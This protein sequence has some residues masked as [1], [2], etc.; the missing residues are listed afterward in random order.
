MFFTIISIGTLFAS[1]TQ[2]DGIWYNFNDN[3]LTAEVTYKGASYDS[4][5]STKYSGTITI[6]TSVTYSGKSYSVTSIGYGAFYRCTGLTSVTIPN[7]VTSIGER[8]FYQ[9]TGLTSVTIGNSVTSIGESAFELCTSLT[10]VTIPDSVI[11]I[12]RCAFDGCRGLTSVTI[13]NS[14]TNIGN[15]VFSGCTSLTSP[16]YNAHVFAYMPTTYSGAYTIPNGIESIAE[17]AFFECAGLTSVIIPNSVTSIGGNAF[18]RCTGLTSVIMGNGITSIGAGAFYSCIS[19]TSVTIPNSV[20]SIGNYAFL[21]CTGLTDIYVSCGDLRRVAQMLNSDDRVKVKYKPLPYS[22]TINTTNG[23]VSAP[24]NICDALELTATPDYGYHFTQW[25][26]G[27]TDNPRAF[28]L[29]Q[30]TTFSAEFA[31]NPTITYVYDKSSGSVNG[32]IVLAYDTVGEITFEATPNYGY[33]FVQWSDGVT[34][35][36]RTAIIFQDTTFAAEFAKNTYSIITESSN[37]EWGTT[38]GNTS[39]LY[40]EQVEIS[41]TANYGYHFLRWSD[42]ESDNPRTIM[43]TNDSVLTAIF[44]PNLYTIIG[45]SDSEKGHIDGIG[46]YDYLTRVT[47]IAIP[48]YGYH[49]DHWSDGTTGN[50]RTIILTQD[51]TFTA[52]FAIDKNGVCG[53]DSALK[54]TYEDKSQ[55]LTITGEGDLTENYTYGVEAPTQMKILIISNDVTSI[56]DSAFYGMTTINHLTIGGNV[57]SIGNYAFAECKNFD[58]ITC[59]ATTVPTIDYTT[60]YNVGNKQY[61]YLYVPADRERA[62]KRDTWWGQF[63]IQIMGATSTETT[64]VNV[65]PSDNSATIVWPAVSGAATYELV[66]K[67]KDGNIICTLIFN[68][69]GQLTSIA[70]NAPGRNAPQQTQSAGFSFTVTGLDS[71][72]GY[73]MTMTSKDSNGAIL[74]TETISFVTNSPQALDPVTGNPSSITHKVIKDGQLFILR[75]DKTYTLTGQEVK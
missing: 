33:H 23:N 44:A 55:T 62:Y 47:L 43:I 11:S 72:T 41:A 38:A 8:A 28:V 60:F 66:I 4:Y 74:Q 73:V 35:N 45:N 49:F 68:E 42:G 7:S 6:P 40:L 18:N 25:S 48:N 37:D 31:K 19:L 30:D 27:V 69:N 58:D 15:L 70:F 20:T 13:G 67:D 16:L 51:T 39:A 64:E 2:V 9:C 56:G 14:A 53:K 22:I 29:T 12:G 24:Q 32:A 75:A 54:W 59:Y 52:I 57:A 1:D 71:G 46:S 36:P 50:P 21:Y 61:I 34:D 10:S 5:S 65:T 17:G 26:D 3:T 63:D